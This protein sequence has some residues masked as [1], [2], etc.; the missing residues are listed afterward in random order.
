M[1][2]YKPMPF[3]IAFAILALIVSI[4]ALLVVGTFWLGWKGEWYGIFAVIFSYYMG[5]ASR[6]FK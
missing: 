2:S 6:A 3:L 1:K 4:I 5:I